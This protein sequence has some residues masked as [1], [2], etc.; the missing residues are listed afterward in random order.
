MGRRSEAECLKCGESFTVDDGGGFYFHLLRCNQCGETKSIGFDEIPEL[1][2]R[3]LNGIQEQ[4]NVGIT[5]ISE[6]QYHS[7]IEILAGNCKCGG[8]F[9]FDALPRCPKCRSEDIREGE[10]TELY[11]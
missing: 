5:P 2:Q 6:N 10:T 4:K 8:K 11:D 3:Y 9:S 7:K 1:H